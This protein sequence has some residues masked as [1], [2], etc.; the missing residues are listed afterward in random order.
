MV[1]GGIYDGHSPE[2]GTFWSG[3]T[4]GNFWLLKLDEN[5]EM[6]PVYEDQE[7]IALIRISEDKNIK[8][9]DE[10]TIIADEKTIIS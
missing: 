2:S 3:Y 5:G 7:L 9:A 4:D 8:F 6:E 10:Q 1:I